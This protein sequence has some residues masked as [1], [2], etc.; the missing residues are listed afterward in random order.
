MSLKDQINENLKN[1]MRSGDTARRDALRTLMAAIKQVEVDTRKTLGDDDVQ[2]VL[3]R[4]AKR[5]RESI[6]GFEKGGRADLVAKEQF[7]LR[8][9]EGYLPQPMSREEIERLARQA[10]A[11]S[12]ATSAAQI[13]AVMQRLMPLVKG[14]A[15]GKLV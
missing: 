14:K 15:D 5:R 2:Q 11:D 7:E 8:L 4:E 12:G 6:E 13:G 9:I 10:V 3:N 1:A